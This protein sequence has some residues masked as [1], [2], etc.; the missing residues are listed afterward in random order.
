MQ[1]AQFNQLVEKAKSLGFDTTKLVKVD[2]S[3]I[4]TEQVTRN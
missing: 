3:I 4:A 1:D 2:H